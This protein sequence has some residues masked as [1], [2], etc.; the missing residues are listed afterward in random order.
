MR[1]F[2]LQICEI[3]RSFAELISTTPN[4]N[5]LEFFLLQRYEYKLNFQRN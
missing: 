3:H 2:F 4:S 5:R 1:N